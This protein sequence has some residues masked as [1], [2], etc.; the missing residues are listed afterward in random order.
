MFGKKQNIVKSYKGRQEVAQKAY[1][2]DAEKLLKKGYFP[3]DDR[4]EEGKWGGGSFFVALLLCFVLIGIIVFIYMA[5]VKPPG[6]LTV[7]YALRTEEEIA[8]SAERKCP[9]CAE[10]IKAAA[11]VCRFCGH[12]FSSSF[13]PAIV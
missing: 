9:R 2:K 13:E 3:S 4:W 10:T 1:L 7:T 12:E 8:D 6:T 11:A 5:L